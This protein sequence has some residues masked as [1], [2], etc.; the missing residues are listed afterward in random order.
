M[1]TS[2]GTTG[3]K[4]ELTEKEGGS[5]GLYNPH[6]RPASISMLKAAEFRE[7]IIYGGVPNL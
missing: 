7:G 1:W 4:H 5:Q 2:Y 3:Q 6:C